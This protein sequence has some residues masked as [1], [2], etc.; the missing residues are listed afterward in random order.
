MSSKPPPV[1]S[2]H[3][4]ERGFTVYRD[5]APLQTPRTLSVTVAQK[6]VADAIVE[7]CHTQGEKLDLRKM[8]MTQMTLTALDIATHHRQEVIDGIMRHGES[9]LLCQRAEGPDDLVLKQHEV[10]QPFLDWS[11]SRFNAEFNVGAGIIPIQQEVEALAAIRSFV[12][13]LDA[14]RL[15]GVSEAVGISGS[16]VLGLAL[17]TNHADVE[18]IF[19]AAE[20]DALWQAKKWGL[21]PATEGRHADIKCDLGD[22]ARW[23]TL[24]D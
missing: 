15:I 9:E 6:K 5:D 18:T 10:W 23:F 19:A 12:E 7:E 20:C 3:H 24:L 16:L 17:A 8:P 4:D 22:C 1:Y 13:T 14:F 21:D 2:V 11:Y